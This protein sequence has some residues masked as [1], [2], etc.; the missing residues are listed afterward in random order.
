MKHLEL[1][2]VNT[3]TFYGWK[4]ELK[5]MNKIKKE[6]FGPTGVNRPCR[7]RIIS[8]VNAFIVMQYNSS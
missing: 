7:I 5:V 3:G 1:E 4:E 6:D 2:Y 8:H